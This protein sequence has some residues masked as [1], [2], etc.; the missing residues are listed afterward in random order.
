MMLV[1]ASTILYI[2]TT[3]SGTMYNVHVSMYMYKEPIQYMC[4]IHVQC[5]YMYVLYST[6]LRRGD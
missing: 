6:V 5:I 3:Y 1:C 2:L 4:C